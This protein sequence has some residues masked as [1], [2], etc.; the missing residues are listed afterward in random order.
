MLCV[1]R[2][3]SASDHFNTRSW[4]LADPPTCHPLHD[5]CPVLDST[6]S[7]EIFRK[8]RPYR[9]YTY[10]HKDEDITP[11]ESH[12]PVW[13]LKTIQL[14]KYTLNTLK[15]DHGALWS[16]TLPQ[17]RMTLSKKS[18]CTVK[19]W[20]RSQGSKD[21]L[22]T[23]YWETTGSGQGLLD[24]WYHSASIVCRTYEG[25]NSHLCGSIIN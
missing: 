2:S 16:V 9:P 12:E 18:S 8:S 21:R 19:V 1:I 22:L 6:S 3:I 4:Q 23:G 17:G 10:P 5:P 13:A 14:I 7:T 11:T 25:Q 15:M 20:R 24:A